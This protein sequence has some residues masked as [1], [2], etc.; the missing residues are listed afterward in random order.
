MTDL[1]IEVLAD[2]TVHPVTVPDAD[3]HQ[4]RD[5][6][7]RLAT[8]LLADAPVA[9]RVVSGRLGRA[10]LP[11]E[12]LVGAGIA[13]GDLVILETEV[14]SGLGAPT[15]TRVAGAMPTVPARPATPA[16]PGRRGR[17]PVVLAVAAAVAVAGVA[18][19]ALV[20]GGD[21]ESPATA[22]TAATVAAR[23]VTVAPR[24]VTRTQVTTVMA[25]AEP[26]AE[27]AEP[28]APSSLS[29]EQASKVVQLGSF[30]RRAN[31]E[32]EAT[33]LRG[34]GLAAEVLDSNVTQELRPDFWVLY[35][36][37]FDD[38]SSISAVIAA[39]DDAGVDGARAR[40]ITLLP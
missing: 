40:E 24:T 15:V 1:D 10:L 11:D 22:A 12:T 6:A 20:V 5:I 29:A 2:G 28:A 25:G 31:A 36:G 37:P 26:T 8:A 39:A 19:A 30:R 16:P 18:A 3:R 9:V 7:P 34:E 21:T 33:R 13:D 4:V 14:P 38:A 17:R 35:A 23:T 27:V 32:R